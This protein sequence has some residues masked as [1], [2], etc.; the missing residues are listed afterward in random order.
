MHQALLW[1]PIVPFMYGVGVCIPST[2]YFWRKLKVRSNTVTCER[3]DTSLME[4]GL[5]PSNKPS[6]RPHRLL[7]GYN[8]RYCAAVRT[9]VLHK[10]TNFRR[11]MALILV[12]FELEQKTLFSCFCYPGLCVPRGTAKGF[13]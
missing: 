11:K 12:G 13:T 9:C 10:I 8:I 2:C 5:V 4:L 3:F 7:L 6:Y 1:P